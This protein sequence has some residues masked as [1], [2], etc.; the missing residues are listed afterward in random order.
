VRFVAPLSRAASLTGAT[1]VVIS[2]F[3]PWSHQLPAAIRHAFPRAALYGIAAHPTAFQVYAIAGEVLL[4]AAVVSAVAGL[5]DQRP[6]QVAAF[7]A[8]TVGLAFSAHALASA[9]TAG[10]LLARSGRAYVHVGARAG[11]GEALALVGFALAFLGGLG[12][13][14]PRAG[15]GRIAA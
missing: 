2:L 9:P 6:L 5:W 14:F 10:L 11:A 3:L 4:V 8:A 13:L 15:T 12:G 7:L 1:L